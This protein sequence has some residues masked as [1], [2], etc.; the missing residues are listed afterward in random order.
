VTLPTATTISKWMYV[1]AEYNSTD[2]KWDVVDVKI[3]A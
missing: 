2:T 3:E 1:E